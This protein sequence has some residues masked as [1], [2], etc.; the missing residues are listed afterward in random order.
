MGEEGSATVLSGQETKYKTETTVLHHPS[1]CVLFKKGL[2]RE[3]ESWLRVKSTGCSSRKLGFGSQHS[4]WLTATSNS[5]FRGPGGIF[6]PSCRENIHTHKI[7]ISFLFQIHFIHVE[8]FFLYMYTCLC[9]TWMQCLQGQKALDAL[10]LVR[11]QCATVCWEISS[12]QC[13]ENWPL[14]Q[15]K[16]SQCS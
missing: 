11:Q 1:L 5:S 3:L 4:Q 13:A 10:K 9:V 16:R 7:S 8:M 15:W 2:F 6:W 14:S 12:Q